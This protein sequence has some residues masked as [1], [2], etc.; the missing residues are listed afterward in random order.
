MLNVAVRLA[1]RAGSS[2]PELADLVR[3]R[4]LAVLPARA[5]LSVGRIDLIIEDV[6]DA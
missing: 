1:I 3:T 2:G 6:D 4:I 5:G